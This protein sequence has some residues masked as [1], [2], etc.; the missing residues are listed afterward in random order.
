VPRTAASSAEAET[1]AAPGIL[2]RIRTI[3]IHAQ[4]VF[5]IFP[6]ILLLLVF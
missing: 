3:M 1:A 5:V 2:L 6:F 4:T